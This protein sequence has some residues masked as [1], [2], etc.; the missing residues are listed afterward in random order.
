MYMC[1]HVHVH[2]IPVQVEELESDNKMMKDAIESGK[3]EQRKK[4]KS[5]SSCDIA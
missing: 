1:M 4:V 3:E 2:V 5:L